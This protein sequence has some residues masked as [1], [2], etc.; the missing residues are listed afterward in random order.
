MFR[1]PLSDLLVLDATGEYP[2]MLELLTKRRMGTAFPIWNTER[3]AIGAAAA[4]P[5]SNSIG[6]Y[7]TH[8]KEAR[9][10]PPGLRTRERRLSFDERDT[11]SSGLP[12]RGRSPCP[13]MGRIGRFKKNR[14]FEPI[15]S[16]RPTEA[17]D[18]G[19]T[20]LEEPAMAVSFKRNRVRQTRR[21][22][23][24]RSDTPRM[25]AIL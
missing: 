6:A 14:L 4:I 18:R 12:F 8:A 25:R 19:D 24:W 17:G 22:S 2:Q 7:Q 5:Q 10:A 23:V 15:G 1:S 20:M 3:D 13:V 9:M 11:D 21:S 16:L